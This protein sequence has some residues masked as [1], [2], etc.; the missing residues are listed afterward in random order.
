M[1]LKKISYFKQSYCRGNYLIYKYC[2]GQAVHKLIFVN[3]NVKEFSH[4]LSIITAIPEQKK[5]VLVSFI[6]G[7]LFS[8]T[9]NVKIITQ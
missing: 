4:C 8:T 6:T 7:I 5:P 1:Y 2:E 9:I 3:F